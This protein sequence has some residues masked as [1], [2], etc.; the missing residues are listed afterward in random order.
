MRKLWKFSS[1]SC[2]IKWK[3]EPNARLALNSVARPAVTRA[4]SRKHFHDKNN[5]LVVERFAKV[6]I[7]NGNMIQFM[8]T[9]LHIF[10]QQSGAFIYAV[11]KQVFVF[12]FVKRL[13]NNE[14]FIT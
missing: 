11:V 12:G 2:S 5:L 4:S 10:V 9:L 13:R 1:S 14:T 8:E 7:E 3:S 6:L